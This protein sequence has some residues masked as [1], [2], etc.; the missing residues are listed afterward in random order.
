MNNIAIRLLIVSC[1]ILN[2]QVGATT[3]ATSLSETTNAQLLVNKDTTTPS[4]MSEINEQNKEMVNERIEET[5]TENARK[6][7][8]IQS[9]QKSKNWHKALIGGGVI[10]LAGAFIGVGYTLGLYKAKNKLGL[11]EVYNRVIR[12]DE[13]SAIEQAIVYNKIPLLIELNQLIESA[14]SVTCSLFMASIFLLEIGSRAKEC[15]F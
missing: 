10:T 11:E 2:V 3:P 8:T 12:G 9:D 6:I 4:E 5:V 13:I 14:T 7:E 1:I 15:N